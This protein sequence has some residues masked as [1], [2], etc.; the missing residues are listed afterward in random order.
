[1]VAKY[2]LQWQGQEDIPLIWSKVDWN[3]LFFYFGKLKIV[4]SNDI[5]DIGRGAEEWEA[6]ERSRARKRKEKDKET[7]KGK[8]KVQKKIKK[9]VQFFFRLI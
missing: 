8:I 9:Y 5:K 6:K 2:S 7:E 1:M 3:R 4:S